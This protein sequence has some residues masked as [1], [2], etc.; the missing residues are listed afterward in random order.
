[1]QVVAVTW[2]E[3]VEMMEARAGGS[4]GG[5]WPVDPAANPAASATASRFAMTSPPRFIPRFL[6]ARAASRQE[7][8]PGHRDHRAGRCG[9]P[10]C[11]QPAAGELAGGAADHEGRAVGIRPP[12]V[13]DW[14]WSCSCF[15]P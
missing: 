6:S 5:R 13:W 12:E 4:G 3:A 10:R 2:D 8:R 9:Q 15:W 14:A 1:D 11:R 7:G